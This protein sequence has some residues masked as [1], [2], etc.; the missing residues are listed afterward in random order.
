MVK[1]AE[2]RRHRYLSAT[3]GYAEYPSHV[4]TLILTLIQ[5]IGIPLPHLNRIQKPETL[6]EAFP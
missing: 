1:L 5:S 2:H 3:N 6:K 4:H